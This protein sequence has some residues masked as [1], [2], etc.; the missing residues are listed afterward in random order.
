MNLLPVLVR[1]GR[2]D[3]DAP[4][5]GCVFHSPGVGGAKP[6]RPREIIALNPSTPPG[7]ARNSDRE[8]ERHPIGVASISEVILNPGSSALRAST[9][10]LR[11]T[12][13]YRGPRLASP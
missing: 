12:D 2:G 9:P 13:P 3:G 11:T 7:V 10:G 6:R 4:R 5:Q 8:R 1:G